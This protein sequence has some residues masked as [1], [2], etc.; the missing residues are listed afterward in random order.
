MMPVMDGYELVEKIRKQSNVPV[1][2]M[3]AKLLGLNNRHMPF[4]I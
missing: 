1:L 4:Y 3:T 2:F